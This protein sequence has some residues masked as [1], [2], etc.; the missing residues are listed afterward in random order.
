MSI[1]RI[2]SFGFVNFAVIDNATGYEMVR[3]DRYT[4][5][6]EFILFFDSI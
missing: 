5:A 3:F 1:V 2:N 6:V 4:D